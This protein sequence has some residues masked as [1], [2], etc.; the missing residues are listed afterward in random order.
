MLLGCTVAGA[1]VTTARSALADVSTV[2]VALAELV[3]PVVA[4]A[5]APSV[6]NVPLAVPA[7]TVTTNA[8]VAELPAATLG[9]VQVIVT[10]DG[11]PQSQPLAAVVE[12][13]VATVVAGRVSVNVAADVAAPPTLATTG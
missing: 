10:P 1:V 9:F 4:V 5:D 11:A 6:R 2:A 7:F 8:K 13:Q 3:P 12:T